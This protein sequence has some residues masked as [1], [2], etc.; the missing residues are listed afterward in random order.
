M[1]ELRDHKCYQRVKG[2]QKVQII[3][4]TGCGGTLGTVDGG[5]VGFVARCST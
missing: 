5:R 3:E 4:V 1:H 2:L